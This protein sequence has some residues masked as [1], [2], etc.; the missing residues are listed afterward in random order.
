MDRSLKSAVYVPTASTESR[1]TKIGFDH[2]FPPL[3]VSVT[4]IRIYFSVPELEIVYAAEVT[5][6]FVCDTTPLLVIHSIV[7]EFW[8]VIEIV[9]SETDIDEMVAPVDE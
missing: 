9:L 1:L 7:V 3:P 5:D 6:V 2:A 8:V 4:L